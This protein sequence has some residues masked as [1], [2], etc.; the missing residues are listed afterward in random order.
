MHSVNA[1]LDN[2][3]RGVTLYVFSDGYVIACVGSQSGTHTLHY[4]N[5]RDALDHIP[6]T[7]DRLRIRE[8]I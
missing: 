6:E 2:Q 4:M 5:I 1:L 3:P 8:G 7:T